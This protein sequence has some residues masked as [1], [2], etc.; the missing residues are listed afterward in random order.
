MVKAFTSEIFSSTY[1]DDFTD[2]DNFHRILFNSGRALQARELTQLQTIMQKELGRLGKHIFKEGASV[3]PGGVTVNNEYEFIKLDTTTLPLPAVITD[4]V[5]VEFTSDSLTKF[6]VLEV[7]AA[8][9]TDPATLYVTYTDTKTSTASST[10]SAPVRVLAGEAIGSTNHDLAVQGTNTVTNPAVGLG[11]KA[12]IH[13]GDFFAQEHFVFARQQSL[14]ISKYTSNPDVRLGFKVTQDI[15]TSSDD[16]S[17]FD[18]QGATPN[19]AS[20]G[21]DRY[22][23]NLTIADKAYVDSDENFIEVA[24]I[25]GGFIQSQV[26]ATDSYNEIANVMALRTKEE[27]GDYIVKPFELEFE[28]NDS[29]TSKINYIVSSGIGYV[30]GY[31]VATS[32]QTAI[33]VSK[34]RTTIAANNE[35]VAANYGSY[36]L[37]SGG[38]GIPNIN[39]LQLMNL[40]TTVNYG[41]GSTIGTARVRHVEEDGANYRL[42][43]FDVSHPNEQFSA[44]RSIGTSNTDFFNL[45]LEVGTAVIKDA[46]NSSLLFELPNSRPQSISDISLA[47]QRRITIPDTGT[48]NNLSVTVPASGETFTDTNLWVMGAADSD[49]DTGVTITGAGTN[50]VSISGVAPNQT[51]YEVL[52]YVNKSAGVVRTKTLTERAQTF[53]TST[54]ADSDGTGNI[55]GYT[56]D[57]PDIFSFE[58]IAE[59]DSAGADKTAI[60]ETDNGQRDNFYTN[61]KLNLVTGNTPPTTLYVKYKHFEHGSGGDFFAVNSYTGQVNYESIPNFTRSNGE[62]INL[63]NVIDFR[64]VV[65]TSGTFGSGARINELPRPTDLITMDVN[66]YIGQ[67]AKVVIGNYGELQVIKGDAAITPELPKSPENTLDLFNVVMNPFMIDDNDIN[68]EQLTYKRFTMADIGKLEQRVSTLEETTALSLLELETSNFDIFDASGLSRTKSGFFVDNFA[69]QQRTFTASPESKSA[70]DPVLQNMRPQFSNRNTNLFYDS[71]AT[72]NFNVRIRGDNI[73]LDYDDV[74]Y[75]SNAFMTGIENVNPFSVVLK[76]GFMEIS[77]TSD[78]WFD[79]EFTEPIVVDG[80]FVQGSVAGSVWNDWSFNWSG[81]K[82]DLK[83]GESLG[84]NTGSNFTSG[85]QIKRTDKEIKISGIKTKTTFI[86]EEGVEVSRAFL[87]YMRTRKIFFKAQGL[88]PNT[89]HYPFFGLKAVDSWVKKE[90]FQR[91][92]SVNQDWSTGYNKLTSHPDGNTAV[93]ETNADGELSGS[94]FLPNTKDIK[95]TSGDKA[96]TLI[97]ISKNNEEDCTSIATAKY[98]AQ[99]VLVHRQQTVL[100]TRSVDIEV[101]TSTTVVGVVQGTNYPGGNNNNDDDNS[102]T[103]PGITYKS[104]TNTWVKNPPDPKKHPGW[105]GKQREQRPPCIHIDPIAQSFLVAET[106]GV[107]ITKIQVRFQSKPATGKTPVV[108][109]L[110]PMVNGIPSSYEAVPGSIVFKSPDAITVSEDGSAITTFTLEEPVYLSGNEEYCIVLL[111]DSDEYNVYVAEAGEFILG[112]TEKKLTRQ[113]TLGS[114]FKSQNGTTWEPDQTKDLT[115]NLVR[116]NFAAGGTVILQNSSPAKVNATNVLKTTNTSNSIQVF[117]PDHGFI[118]GSTVEISGSTAIGNIPNTQLDGVH[119]VT[120]VSGDEF[121]FTV[122]SNANSTAIGGGDIIIERQHMFELARVGVENILPPA[123]AINASARLTTGKSTAGTETAEQVDTSYTPIAINK[124]VYFNHPKLLA[125]SRNETNRMSG[126][127]SALIK[128]ELAAG[129]SFVSPVVDLQRTSLTTIHNRIDNNNA[130]NS[131]AETNS[132]G[133]TT[134]A[135]H[136]TKPVTLSEE[137][138]GLKILLSA[139]KPSTSDFDVYYRTNSGGD[140]LTSSY[141]LIA[142]ETGIPASDNP[143]IFRDYRYLPGGIGGFNFT[144]DQFQIKIVMRSTNNAKVPTFGDLRVIALTV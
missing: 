22:R 39:E 38:K 27:S 72:D 21:A 3:N 81:V 113:A 30:D 129:N 18:N 102:P 118:V 112:S 132:I 134:L 25:V 65:N 110:R 53:T 85:N 56:F 84:S 82:K 125:T 69:D 105:T 122:A 78:E 133:G 15:V 49:I 130:F 131:V 77:P 121:K 31:R 12:S 116:A 107:F 83:V 40:R 139:N 136:V 42:Y 35:V 109:Q 93:L 106:S 140:L 23:I 60:F 119:T 54:D 80:G 92:S 89:R 70:I 90:T 32:G 104:E 111:S 64:P 2:S 44:V 17:L 126:A 138:K 117:L 24:N 115:F 143:L 127:P 120:H 97:D 71:D 1:R 142:P 20:P 58:I 33:V 57:K 86:D 128:L 7:V 114:L 51:A 62:I 95:F 6:K 66:Y 100:S 37:V 52:A 94:F 141:T 46:A 91:S 45:V 47:V 26:G 137:S 63:R 99:G 11:T 75:I 68:S 13:A 4:L 108:A 29:D 36:I 135:K 41:S 5:G 59:T 123:T 8:T 73:M 16:N 48:G 34:P 101:T 96:F 98:Y 79:T 28:T 55:T 10:N 88:K 124:N 103:G 61:G 74:D 43:L 67:A 50:T 87:P 14:I 144:F 9:A 76:R 19:L